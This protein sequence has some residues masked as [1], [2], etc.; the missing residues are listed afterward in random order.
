MKRE[1]DLIENLNPLGI[2]AVV[3]LLIFILSMGMA[4]YKIASDRKVIDTLQ[5]ENNLLSSEVHH[6]QKNKRR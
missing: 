2:C 6:L 3:G 1:K 5:R 4:I